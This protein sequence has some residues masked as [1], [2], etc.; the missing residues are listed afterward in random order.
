M[1]HL[2]S[3]GVMAAPCDVA[4]RLGHELDRLGRLA[5]NMQGVIATL[6]VGDHGAD[7]LQSLDVVTQ[8]LFALSGFLGDWALVLDGT[9]AANIGEALTNISLSAIGHRLAGLG[10]TAGDEAGVVELFA[11]DI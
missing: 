2:D 1:T 4:L 10:R 8:S 11:A 7:A 5:D 6:G 3:H 9:T